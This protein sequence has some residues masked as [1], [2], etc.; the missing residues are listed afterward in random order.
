MCVT[1]AISGDQT[2]DIS[3]RALTALSVAAQHSTTVM[4]RGPTRLS[5]Q[6]AVSS[7]ASPALVKEAKS[8]VWHV[9]VT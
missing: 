9:R 6:V 1:T 3:L 8:K 2:W 5:I 4:V 7:A